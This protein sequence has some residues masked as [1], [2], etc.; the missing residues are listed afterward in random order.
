[1]PLPE[2]IGARLAEG[3]ERG[4]GDLDLSATFLT[5]AES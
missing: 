2:A 1:V 4:H 5:S 3:V